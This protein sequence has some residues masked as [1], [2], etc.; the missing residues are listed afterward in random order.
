MVTDKFCQCVVLLIQMLYLTPTKVL[1]MEDIKELSCV[2]KSTNNLSHK[3]TIAIESTLCLSLQV[4]LRHGRTVHILTMQ[5]GDQE[6]VVERRRGFLEK[7]ARVLY[8]YGIV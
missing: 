6:F 7:H 8:T 2:D 5:R 3:R 4:K 1:E